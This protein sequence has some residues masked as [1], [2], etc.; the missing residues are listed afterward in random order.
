MST[1]KPVL[2]ASFIDKQR[3]YLLRLQGSLRAAARASETDEADVRSD[4][5][6][7]A[8]EYED[9]AQKLAALELDGNLVVRDQERLE[10]VDRALKKID[11]GSY[12]LSDLSGLPI[13]RERLEAIP[14]ATCTLAE[15]KQRDRQAAR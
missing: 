12:G 8:Q 14:E 10:R 4:S 9:D 2:D 6:D 1:G 3:Q 7:T 11:E 13:P 15:E 5:A